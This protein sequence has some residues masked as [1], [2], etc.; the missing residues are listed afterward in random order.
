M[1]KHEKLVGLVSV[2]EYTYYA[3]TNTYI[4]IVLYLLEHTGTASYLVYLY[5]HIYIYIYIYTLGCNTRGKPKTLCLGLGITTSE[6][7]LEGII[8]K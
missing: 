7:C 2:C 3:D 8:Q 4:T 6:A 1:P 5:D